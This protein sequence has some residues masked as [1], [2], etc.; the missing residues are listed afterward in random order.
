MSDDQQI[1]VPA[2][3]PDE[4][5]TEKPPKCDAAAAATC[6]V[7]SPD[8]EAKIIDVF[9][10]DDAASPAPPPKDD[11]DLAPPPNNGVA[12]MLDVVMTSQDDD[13]AIPAPTPNG[14]AGLSSPPNIAAGPASP[15][16]EDAS[17]AS[18]SKE[19]ASAAPPPKEDA[20]PTPPPEEDAITAQPSM[21]VDT[22]NPAD[23]QTTIPIVPNNEPGCS[24]ANGTA[25]TDDDDAEVDFKKEIK[26][27]TIDLGNDTY[28]YDDNNK[29]ILV[30]G[31]P[32]VGF[33]RGLEPDHIVGATEQDGK[34]MFLIAWKNSEV[35][36]LL[37][38]T[39]VYDRAPQI[40]IQFF[41]ARLRYCCPAN[42]NN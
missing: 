8:D 29:P 37:E 25:A 20:I 2:N 9:D 42:D 40:A 14:D 35:A 31:Y 18:P 1:I 6:P 33:D 12:E 39:V 11:A 41:E 30:K 15:P 10:D 24:K 27:E 34:L 3:R 5:S 21:D 7:Q 23:G 28:F 36:D 22:A 26:H 19:D 13:A 17:A 4:C 38:S 16:K 32:K